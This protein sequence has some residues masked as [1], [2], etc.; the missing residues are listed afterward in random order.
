MRITV[1]NRTLTYVN[2]VER[3]RSGVFRWLWELYPCLITSVQHRDVAIL[4]KNRGYQ[5]IC[6]VPLEDTSKT[7]YLTCANA[8]VV[9]PGVR[10]R[11]LN[12]LITSIFW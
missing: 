7:H 8:G 11:T 10:K 5:K 12:L 6:S 4:P 9:F 1:L 3:M 2:H